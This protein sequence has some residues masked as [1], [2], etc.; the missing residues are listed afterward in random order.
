MEA[1]GDMPAKAEEHEAICEDLDSIFQEHKL[2][3]ESTHKLLY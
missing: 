3:K 1:R 2:N